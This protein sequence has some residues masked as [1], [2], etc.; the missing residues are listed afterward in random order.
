MVNYY[1]FNNG[2]CFGA[3]TLI[4]SVAVTNG[5]V[6]GSDSLR[7]ATAGFFSWNASYDNNPLQTVDTNNTPST[8][9]CEPLFVGVT[10][11]TLVSVVTGTD[12]NLYWNTFTGTWGAWQPLNGQSPSPPSLCASGSS[13]TE[14]LVRGT[15]NGIYHKTFSGGTFTATWQRNPTGVT[16]G[17]PVCAVIGTTLYVV[18][19]GATGE[20]F[21]TTFDLLAHTWA[22]SWIDLLGSSPSTPALAA[23][24]SLTRLDLVVRGDDNQIYHKAFV[25]GAWA[26]AWDTSNR[27]P[28]PD[29]T[30]ASPVIVSDGSTLHV[31]V[32]G[33]ESNIW[34]ATRSFAGAW[35]TYTSL[36]GAASIAPALTIDSAGALHLIVRGFDA[37]M[38]SKSKP[39]GGSW[40]AA[41]VNAGGVLA[42]GPAAVV[43]GSSVA[44]L[45]QGVDNTIWYNT[46]TGATWSGFV[47]TNGQTSR[48][49]GISTP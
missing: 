12:G 23:T 3:G 38:Y 43:S 9:G 2:G 19:R 4:T 28:V 25:S 1:Q 21:Y 29:K 7:F 22:A 20:L 45:V 16:I 13:S 24:P 42:S 36:S 11:P 40:D 27:S 26:A 46:L 44:V 6:P 14:L 10:P 8:S 17:Q 47:S 33:T 37:Q 49:A 48:S 32:I 41:W 35:S 39:S 15:D 18:V 34:Y 30:I 31:I 5:V